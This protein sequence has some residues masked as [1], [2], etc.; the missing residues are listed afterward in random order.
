MALSFAGVVTTVR[1]IN[2]LDT[3]LL[4]FAVF[5]PFAFSFFRVETGIILKPDVC[6]LSVS[7]LHVT[8]E[9]DILATVH[10]FIRFYG[11][12]SFRLPYK[13]VNKYTKNFLGPIMY[14]T[15]GG[16]AF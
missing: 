8:S 5:I 16:R 14:T 3:E 6:P 7:S 4:L 1:V 9:S 11:Q 13:N 2:R 15:E 12:H 10:V